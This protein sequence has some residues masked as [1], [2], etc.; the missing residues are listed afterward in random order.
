MSTN[1]INQ[2]QTITKTTKKVENEIK[3]TVQN[4]NIDLSNIDMSVAIDSFKRLQEVS[5]AA[6]FSAFS[7]KILSLKAVFADFQKSVQVTNTSITNFANSADKLSGSNTAIIQNIEVNTGDVSAQINDVTSSFGN[8]AAN[9]SSSATSVGNSFVKIG[10]GALNLGTGVSS[11]LDSVSKL[12]TSVENLG[13]GLNTAATGISALIPLLPALGAAMLGM[14]ENMSGLLVYVPE[15]LVF[16][17][18]LA[19]LS[20]MG[21]G[22]AAAGTGLTGIG[23]GLT[24]MTEG[25][26]ALLAFMPVFIQSLAGITENVGGIIMFVLLAAAIL[27]MAVALET[28]NGQLEL[29]VTSMEKLSTLM[30]AGFVLAFGVFSVLLIA[31]SLCMDKAAKGLDKITAAMEK[32]IGKLTVLNPLLAAQA[33]L[34]N[35]IVG[36]ITVAA[37]IAGGLLVGAVL[38]KMAT[39]GVVSSPTVTL[40]GEGRYPEAVVPLGDSPQ[41]SEMKTD[42]ANAVLTGI[43]A[44]NR[45]GSAQGSS[46]EVVINVDGS[47]LARMIIPQ[48]NKEQRRKGYS[49]A[50]KEV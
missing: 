17:G 16:S 42:I 44:M 15:L 40:V 21:E 47:R 23:A 39:G 38:P 7:N 34:T 26:S 18:I 31:M 14:A 28:M 13:G 4:I 43:S 29:F 32:Q 36:A 8:M 49:A 41:F 24:S 45:Q 27:V 50:L 3:N 33:I 30:S 48:I 11:I 1:I 25:M 20:L 35:P 9:I 10:E 2:S 5:Q 46:S 12:F 6:D 19:V 37:A 22:L